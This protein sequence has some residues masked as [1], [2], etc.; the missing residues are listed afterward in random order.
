MKCKYLRLRL[1]IDKNLKEFDSV[2]LVI[3]EIW[4]FLFQNV[5]WIAGQGLQSEKTMTN[6]EEKRQTN[7]LMMILSHAPPL[8]FL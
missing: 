4:Y 8:I 6:D 2:I 1:T 7:I 5:I 3:C